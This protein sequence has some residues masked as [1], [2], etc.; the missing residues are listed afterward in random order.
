MGNHGLTPKDGLKRRYGTKIRAN[1]KI[2]PYFLTV[3][4]TFQAIFKIPSDTKGYTPYKI[5][6]RGEIFSKF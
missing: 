2:T 4:T 5:V 1:L 3:T 6:V